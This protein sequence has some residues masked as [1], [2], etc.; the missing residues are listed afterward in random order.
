[1]N[2]ARIA[3]VI[4]AAVISVT[5][6]TAGAAFASGPAGHGATATQVR[7]AAPGAPGAMTGT[8]RRM[9]REYPAIAAIPGQMIRGT[10]GMGQMDQQMTGGGLAGMMGGNSAA[11][12]GPAG[13]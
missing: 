13:R 4:G 8:C 10:R 9:M 11:M 3:A 6:G 12:A 5:A 7:P 1:V 2:P